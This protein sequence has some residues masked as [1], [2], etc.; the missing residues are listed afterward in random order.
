M[1][2]FVL[3]GASAL[4]LAACDVSPDPADGGFLSGIVGVVGGGYQSR[5]DALEAQ[6]AAD[7]ARANALASEQLRLQAAAASTSAQLRNLRA[8]F[9]ALQAVIRDQTATLEAK[10]IT[11]NSAL[12]AKVQR[13]SAAAPGGGDTAARLASLRSAIADA[14]ALSADLS[15]LS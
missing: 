3:L 2:R 7:Q 13:V 9:A 11:V 5:I 4:A 1:K 12:K 8:Q 10:G 15:R 14:R 6:L